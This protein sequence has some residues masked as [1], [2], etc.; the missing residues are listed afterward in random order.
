MCRLGL[1]HGDARG[2]HTASAA[3]AAHIPWRSCRTR[4]LAPRRY[5]GGP[6]QGRPATASRPGNGTVQLKR[7]GAIEGRV[8]GPDGKLLVHAPLS[9]TTVVEYPPVP[10]SGRVARHLA[11]CRGVHARI[12][13]RHRESLAGDH[14]RARAFHIEGV[15]PGNISSVLSLVRADAG[16]VESGRWRAFGSK[17]DGHLVVSLPLAGY[18]LVKPVT[19]YEAATAKDVVLDFSQST[20]A[21]EGKVHDAAGKPVSGATVRL[22]WPGGDGKNW[23]SLD[24]PDVVTDAAGHYRIDHLPPGSLQLQAVPPGMKVVPEKSPAAVQVELV[25]GQVLW[26]DLRLAPAV[27]A[28]SDVRDTSGGCQ[29]RRPRPLQF[30]PRGY[31]KFARAE[32]SRWSSA[33]RRRFRQEAG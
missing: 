22:F 4:I 21:V 5:R 15:P 10:S 1:L 30:V 6:R 19:V 20:A 25:A 23:M 29:A 12:Q 17:K 9:L 33:F 8:L 7:P 24:L 27:S 13:N 11:R 18:G 2:P 28:E 16:E 14:R 3:A 32:M 31:E 26:Q